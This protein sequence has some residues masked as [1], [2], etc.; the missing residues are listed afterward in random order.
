MFRGLKDPPG[1][2]GAEVGEVRHLILAQADML[3]CPELAKME[4]T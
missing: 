1:E 3:S 4:V 2:W